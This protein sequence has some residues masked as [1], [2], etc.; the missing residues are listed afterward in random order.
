MKLVNLLFV[1][2]PIG[3]VINLFRLIAEHGKRKRIYTVIG[4][5]D[6]YLSAGWTRV[7]ASESASHQVEY[8]IEVK[9]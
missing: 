9:P 4:E 7:E 3:A 8:W 2:N 1:L 5:N 6:E